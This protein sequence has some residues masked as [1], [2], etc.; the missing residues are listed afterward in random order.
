MTSP[1]ELDERFADYYQSPRISLECNENNPLGKALIESFFPHV[2]PDGS[3]SAKSDDPRRETFIL[4]FGSVRMKFRI[5]AKANVR[6]EYKDGS[7]TF[8]TEWVGRP[9]DDVSQQIT[10]I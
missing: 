9:A 8:E 3:R 6:A 1:R 10:R 5:V 2:N 7:V 4:E